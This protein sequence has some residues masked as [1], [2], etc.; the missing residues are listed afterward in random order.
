MIFRSIGLFLLIA[1]ASIHADAQGK[2]GKNVFVL[3]PAGDA[4]PLSKKE[5][6]SGDLSGGEISR[7]TFREVT[8]AQG[9]G[10]GGFNLLRIFRGGEVVCVHGTKT[11][12]RKTWKS[13][14]P[15]SLVDGL[16]QALNEDR[17][18]EIEGLY[19]A[20]LPQ[21]TQGFVELSMTYGRAYAWLDNYFEPLE[22][23][24]EYCNREI[25][26]VVLKK[27]PVFGGEMA[28]GKADY[29]RIFQPE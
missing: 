6:Q 12:K 27:K 19:S 26:P 1:G 20:A 18:S 17:V 10:E 13:T 16:M 8:L 4:L 25:W 11:G 3:R 29:R 2:S 7:D 24:F 15:V 9:T 23:S 21:G 14:I 22:K 5:N 28:D